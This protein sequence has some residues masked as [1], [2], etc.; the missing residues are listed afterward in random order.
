MSEGQVPNL[1]ELFAKNSNEAENGNGQAWVDVGYA[2]LYGM[3]CEQNIEKA[4]DCFRKGAEEGDKRACYAIYDTWDS[5]VSLVAE[6]EAMEMFRRA[7]S[8]RHKEAQKH[9]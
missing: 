7:A 2:Y 3:G 9:G 6:D 1:S 5:G 4:L 8:L